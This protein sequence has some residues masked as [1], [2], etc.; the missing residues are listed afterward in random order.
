MNAQ[1]LEFA[2]K[3]IEGMSGA[4]NIPNEF[5]TRFAELVAAHEREECAQVI[6][7]HGPSLAN[8]EMLAEAI[9]A[10]GTT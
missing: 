9:R 4:W 3:A 5:C 2:D 6:E 1:I 10:R 7:S 8:G